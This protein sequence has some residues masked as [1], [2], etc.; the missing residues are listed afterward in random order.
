MKNTQDMFWNKVNKTGSCWVWTGSKDKD[1]YGIQF[2]LNGQ[3]WKPH[4][5]SYYLTT[6]VNPQGQVVCHKCDNPAC[7]NPAHLFLG[8]QYDNIQD[9]VNKGRHKFGRSPGESN[10]SAKLT[11]QQVLEIRS[12]PGPN[13]KIA[14]QYGVSKCTIDE[15]RSGRTWRHLLTQS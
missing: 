10:P 15:I 4:R 9:M 13:R 1:G 7:V 12:L 14:A 6:G 8:S 2:T 11:E 3:V 5:L